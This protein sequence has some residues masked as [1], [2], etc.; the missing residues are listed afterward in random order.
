MRASVQIAR[1]TTA[2]T[3]SSMGARGDGATLQGPFFKH[4]KTGLSAKVI[5]NKDMAKKG[6]L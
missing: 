4:L 2:L 3:G 6:Y 1:F 5:M